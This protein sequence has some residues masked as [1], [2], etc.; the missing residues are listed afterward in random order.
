MKLRAYNVGDVFTF[1][2]ILSSISGSAGNELR[3]LLR[4]GGKSEVSEKEAEDR[5]IELVL[6]VLQKAYAGCKNKLIAWLASL[7]EK[8][9]DDF[10][11]MPPET[12]L[13]VIKE[14]ATGEE[15]TSFFTKASRLFPQTG[16]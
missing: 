9:V 4:S 1:V 16:K 14:V 13:E 12:V 2:D 5:G 10:L 8:S 6:F 7:L 3:S 15:S 11:K